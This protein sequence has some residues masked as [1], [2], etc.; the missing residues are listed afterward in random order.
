MM[1]CLMIKIILLSEILTCHRLKYTY[2]DINR[3]I[4]PKNIIN[5]NRIPETIDFF[6]L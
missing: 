3:V 6:L 4:S 1:I 5:N 2:N